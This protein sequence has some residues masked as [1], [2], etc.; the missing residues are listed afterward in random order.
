MSLNTPQNSLDPVNDFGLAVWLTGLGQFSDRIDGVPWKYNAA[1][2]VAPRSFTPLM[3]ILGFPNDLPNV[4]TDVEPLVI[5]YAG[6]APGLS[7]VDQVNLS[8]ANPWSRAPVRHQ[9]CHVPLYLTDNNWS[10]SQLV[11]V[12]IKDGGG[13]CADPAQAGMGTVNWTKNFISDKGG[14]SSTSDQVSVTFWKGNWIAFPAPAIDDSVHY[15]SGPFPGFLPAVHAKVCPGLS[16]LTLDEGP[17]VLSGPASTPVSLTASDPVT[18]IYSATLPPGAIAGGS[19]QISGKGFT[20]TERIPPPIAITTVLA[21]GTKVASTLTVNWTGGDDQSAVTVQITAFVEA[22]PFK[23][24]QTV[25]A[26]KGGVTIPVCELLSGGGLCEQAS[27]AGST[28]EVIVT[29]QRVA[30][31]LAGN[32]FNVPGLSLGGEQVWTYTWDFRGLSLASP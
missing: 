6:P 2:N 9:G 10:A 25:L 8:L 31:T 15:T 23:A 32:S 17:L 13:P 21:P 19:Y 14:V 20:D 11:T 18:G 5:A 24:I 7:G 12:S 4:R 22:T 16:P 26:S 29:Q 28:A 3:A 1:D 27:I 30:G